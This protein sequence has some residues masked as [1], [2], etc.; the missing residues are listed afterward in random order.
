MPVYG[1]VGD[2]IGRR[3]AFQLAIAVFLAGSV[4]AG[5]APNMG[6]LISCRAIQG[7]GA[8]GLLIGAQTIMADI[9]SA[10]ERGKYMAVM[11]PMIGVATVLGPLSAAT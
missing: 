5:I 8:G 3:N 11:G 1:K 7:I 4:V 10:R 2:F 9:V 6:V